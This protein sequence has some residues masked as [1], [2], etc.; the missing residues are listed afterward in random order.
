MKYLKWLFVLTTILG[1]HAPASAQQI[2]LQSGHNLFYRSEISDAQFSRDGRWLASA[3]RNEFIN[4]GQLLIWNDQKRVWAREDSLPSV[5]SLDWSADGRF[6]AIGDDEGAKIWSR[7]QKKTIAATMWDDKD[8]STFDGVSQVK[9]LDDHRVAVVFREHNKKDVSDKPR[10]PSLQIWD[11]KKN[12]KTVLKTLAFDTLVQALALSPNGETLAM[13]S[14]GVELFDLASG[15][16]RSIKQTTT[17]SYS[18]KGEVMT[19]RDLKFSPNGRFLIGFLEGNRYAT[20]DV[21]QSA[22]KSVR[23]IIGYRS[24][25]AYNIDNNGDISW[26]MRQENE[27]DTSFSVEHLQN[28][29]LVSRVKRAARHLRLSY[30]TIVDSQNRQFVVI[31]DNGDL[32]W[33]DATTGLQTHVSPAVTQWANAVAFSPD[34]ARLVVGYGAE[35]ESE[36]G[37]VGDLAV[38]DVRKGALV[39]GIIAHSPSDTFVSGVNDVVFSPD[40]KYLLTTCNIS[41][42]KTGIR[43]LDAKSLRFI[44]DVP[45]PG[46]SLSKM[47]F[48]RDGKSFVIGTHN[49]KVLFWKDFRRALA[50]QKPDWSY[51][52]TQ[53]KVP[54][55]ALVY[56]LEIAPD[57]KS[58]LAT[59][60]HGSIVL[61]N[62][63][64]GA[65]LHR[66][67]DGSTVGGAVFSGDGQTFW[68]GNEKG[69]IKEW[70]AKTYVLRRVLQK[71]GDSCNAMK[72]SRD[73]KHL[74]VALGKR[75]VAFNVQT[76]Q[77]EI[78][79]DSA[80]QQINALSVSP[81]GKTLA[82]AD[83]FGTAQL[84]D[85]QTGKRTHIFNRTSWNRDKRGF[86]TTRTATQMPGGKVVFSP[87]NQNAVLRRDGDLMKPIS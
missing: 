54:D 3:T 6:L 71:T 26:L 39:R 45:L 55:D 19:P 80:P 37:V 56:A 76:G 68:T 7:E 49:D 31:V 58:V 79:F 40:G 5:Q 15:K 18:G 86:L 24:P 57:Q 81:D 67:N 62:A 1:A 33:F 64:N 59:F 20:F 25:R 51:Q 78:A 22:L 66:W 35:L 72:L 11:W 42:D 28:D 48:S 87:G 50:G 27:N 43:V 9:C 46:G 13:S 30:Q 44:R 29:K 60:N 17:N 65:L 41:Y 84:Y 23:K 12:I 75:V 47:A 14:D 70:N 32:C 34:G 10:A 61:L 4:A 82:S 73:Q 74:H 36:S 83:E 16:S 52:K 53:K 85:T 69:E 2:V 63:Q 21:A 8:V 38:F 77:R